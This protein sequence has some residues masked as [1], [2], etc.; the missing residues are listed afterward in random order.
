MSMTRDEAIVLVGL[1]GRLSRSRAIEVVEALWKVGALRLRKP[2]RKAVAP[3]TYKYRDPAKR[4]E[5]MRIYMAKVRAGRREANA[6]AC[7][8]AS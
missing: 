8:Q 3:Q 6:P 5:Y 1:K 4:R 7:S 2:T